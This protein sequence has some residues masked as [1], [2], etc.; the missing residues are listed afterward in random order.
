MV[1]GAGNDT[2][3]V[4]GKDQ[5]SEASGGGTDTVKSGGSFTLGAN[6]EKLILTGSA[7]AGG[8]GNGGAN[9]LTGNAGANS[10]SGLGGA[11]TLLGLGGNDA[12][13]GGTGN[14]TLNGGG[15]N[16]AFVFDTA[17]NATGNVD[18]IAD[19]VHGADRIRLDDDV[20][21]AL[22]GAT[23]LTAAQFRSG[24][25]VTTAADA[26]DRILYDTSTGALYYDRDGNGSAAAAIK[27]AVLAGSP[28]ALSASDFAVI[29]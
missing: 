28:D 15:G 20:F 1:G 29:G 18:R 23:S 6:L 26:D 14:D 17:L 10:L 4:S 11:D 16:D 12:L 21:T 2:Y 3:V 24:A 8:T 7:N 22:A 19:F 9:T 13:R 27:F 5:L 25:G